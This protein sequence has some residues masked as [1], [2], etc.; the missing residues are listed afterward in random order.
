MNMEVNDAI[1][2]ALKTIASSSEAQDTDALIKMMEEDVN[3]KVP[4]LQPEK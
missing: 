1:N 3:G 4:E 2:L